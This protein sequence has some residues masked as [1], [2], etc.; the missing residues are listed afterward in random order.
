MAYCFQSTSD[1][2]PEEILGI[3]RKLLGSP[4]PLDSGAGSEIAVPPQ[5]VSPNRE[6]SLA[7]ADI[8]PSSGSIS[9]TASGVKDE[10][11]SRVEH[12]TVKETKSDGYMPTLDV[13]CEQKES[14][15]KDEAT[16]SAKQEERTPELDSEDSIT[17]ERVAEEL[18]R[19]AGI[20]RPRVS[21]HTPANAEE[22]AN[23]SQTT[24]R[25]REHSFQKALESKA[26]V[27]VLRKE[28]ED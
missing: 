7:E 12:D 27:L 25:E 28:Q 23:S 15:G 11:Q 24:P 2:I 14:E 6:G 19:L 8:Q 10:P 20:Q 21:A 1:R 16:T 4:A 13:K 26:M 22:E 5:V 9:Q 3:D 18:H 17:A